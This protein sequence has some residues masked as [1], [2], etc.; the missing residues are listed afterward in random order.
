MACTIT[1]HFYF[2]IPAIANMQEI[3]RKEPLK[4]NN[5]PKR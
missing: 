3:K 5:Q 1:G 4:N 2:M